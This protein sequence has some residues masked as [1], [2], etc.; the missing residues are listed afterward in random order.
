MP[1]IRRSHC[2]SC[3][4]SSSS[5]LPLTTLP[6]PPNTLPLPFLSLSFI[7]V[8][9]SQLRICRH[10]K[11]GGEHTRTPSLTPSPPHPLIPSLLLPPRTLN[12]PS[13]FL[14][15]SPPPTFAPLTSF[16][17][18]VNS[19]PSISPHAS[20]WFVRSSLLPPPPPPPQ[21]QPPPLPVTPL[22]APTTPTPPSLAISS[23]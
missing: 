11:W 2:T 6:P 17:T 23:F 4:P 9:A 19:Y 8:I 1:I 22:A 16:S 20:P 13:P 3:I 18:R 14:R 12:S 15:G 7:F 10:K 21:T 5:L